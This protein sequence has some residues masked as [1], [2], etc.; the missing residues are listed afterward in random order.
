ML[1][2]SILVISM[3]AIMIAWFVSAYLDIPRYN[4]M[5][6]IDSAVGELSRA[7]SAQTPDEVI[8]HITM[9]KVMLPQSGYISWWSSDKGDFKIIQSELDEIISRAQNV[10]GLEIENRLFNSE[11]LD[12]H[13]KLKIIQETLLGL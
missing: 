9:A 10:S 8:S 2:K 3:A 13:A 12:I 11:M 1:Q 7:Q 5:M 4:A 6:V